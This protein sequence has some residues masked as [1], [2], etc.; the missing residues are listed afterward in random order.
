[1]EQSVAD[2][3]LIALFIGTF[4]EGETAALLAG[5]ASFTGQLNYYS[6]VAVAALGS[7]LGDQAW[8]QLGRYFGRDWLA[9]RPS[10]APRV[11]RVEA[12]LD[13]H[14]NWIIVSF[15]FMYGLRSAVPFV[16]GASDISRAKF[17]ALNAIGASAWA[18]LIVWLGYRFGEAVK[19]VL[20]SV[21]KYETELMV[22]IVSAG[23]LVWLLYFIW[24]RIKVPKR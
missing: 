24:R 23:L 16:L 7:F 21:K 13:K 9:K 17:A 18:C 11:S 8:F 4:L 15:R 20:G 22:L 1:M 19:P 3:G 5:F 6:V 14:E 10:W 2:W 12:M